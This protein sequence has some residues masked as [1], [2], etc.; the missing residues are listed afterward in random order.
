[1]LKKKLNIKIFA[2]N[3]AISFFLASIFITIL[4][5]LGEE[6]INHYTTIIN[7]LAV[8]ESAQREAIYD[9]ESNRLIRYPAYGKKYANIKIPSIDL[10]LP[11]YY[12]DSLKILRYGIGHYAGSYFP[13]EG[14]TILL[15]GHNNVG[16]FNKLEDVKIGDTVEIIA[17]YGT[18]TYKVI[19]SKVVNENDLDAFA[20]ENKKEVLIMYTCWPI[21]R[22][23]VG[24]K[25]ERLVVYAEK[26]G[27]SYE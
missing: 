8:N 19:E 16:I 5:F 3:V 22:S 15:A 20:I 6:K 11:L 17:N 1:M 25:T 23:V 14:G 12:G 21:N 27:E 18:Y 10:D 2:T 9:K 7:K 24:R 26:V 4:Y 13:G